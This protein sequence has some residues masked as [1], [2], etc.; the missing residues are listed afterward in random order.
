MQKITGDPQVVEAV[1]E[2]LRSQVGFSLTVC[3]DCANCP[4]VHHSVVEDGNVII[5][6]DASPHAPA[7][8]LTHDQWE[9]LKEE[10][11]TGRIE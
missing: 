5:T 7:V 3:S 11:R 8:L 4:I 2:A 6:N 1:P 9:D 10:I